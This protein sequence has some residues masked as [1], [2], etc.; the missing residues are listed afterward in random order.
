MQES[1]EPNWRT[2]NWTIWNQNQVELGAEWNWMEL[3]GTGWNRNWMELDFDPYI[4]AWKLN[5][6]TVWSFWDE[7]PAMSIFSMR[8]T[9]WF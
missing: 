1:R 7:N 3:D 2:V 6:C 9:R 5:F 8:G 4:G